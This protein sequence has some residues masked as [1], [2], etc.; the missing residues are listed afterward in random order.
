YAPPPRKRQAAQQVTQH[1]HNHDHGFEGDPN[2]LLDGSGAGCG[3][4]RDTLPSLGDQASPPTV[5]AG[6]GG[7]G[8]SIARVELAGAYKVLRQLRRSSRPKREIETI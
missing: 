6:G 5:E 4:V 2:L 3:V 1:N 7:D 8:E